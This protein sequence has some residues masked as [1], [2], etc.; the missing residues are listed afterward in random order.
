[1]GKKLLTL[2]FVSVLAFP[3]STAVFAQEAPA[4]EKVAKEARWEGTVVRSNPDKSTL[5]VRKAGTST[6]EMTIEYD[7]STK[8]VSQYHGD[9][10]VN[11]IDASQVK[12][13]DYVICKGSADGSIIHASLVS[14]RLTH[15]N[16]NQ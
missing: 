7:S 5:T 4:K 10:K 8:W 2:L 15:G 16:A 12:D 3:L 14:K 6:A 1:M 11:D 13:G 9:K